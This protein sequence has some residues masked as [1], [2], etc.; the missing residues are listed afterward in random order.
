MSSIRR[1]VRKIIREYLDIDDFADIEQTARLAH[2]GQERR[3]GTPYITHPFAVRAITRKHY[4][5]N[6]EAQALAILHDTLEDGPAQGNASYQ[7]LEDMI[8]H[9]MLDPESSRA[10]LTALKVMTHD[11]SKEDYPTY[12]ARVFNNPLASIVK[13][14][15]LIHNLSHKPKESQIEKYKNALSMVTIPG[16]I[17][18]SH[19]EE[20]TN[21]LTKRTV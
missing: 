4:P 14:S 15:D 8:T 16:H 2:L 12:L 6:L 13:I 1:Y 9:S 7:E 19:L 3:D 5:D 18:S 10:V 20:L 17:K 11:K 21:I